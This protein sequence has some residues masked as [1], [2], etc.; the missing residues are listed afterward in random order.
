MS[1]EQIL[2]LEQLEV[3]IY[4]GGV[5]SPDSGYFQRTFG[6][7]VAGQSLVSAVRTVDPRYQVHSLHGYF[8]RPGDAK[9]RT[10]FIV[11]R[12][13]DGGSFATRRV[14]AIQHGEIIFSMG[15]SFQTDQEGIHHQDAM[16]AAPPPDGLPGLD[17]IKVFDDAGFKQFEEWD[18]CIVPREKLQLTPG[19]ASQQQVWFRHRDPL[20]DDPVLHICALAYMS[21]LTLLG[22]AQVTHLDVREHLQV[23]SLDHAMWFMRAFRADKWLL[24]DQSSPSANGGRSLCQGK[25]FT[26]SGEMV[27]AVMQE[28]LTRFQ[29]GYRQ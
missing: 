10:V 3:N 11:E 22:S 8:L 19:K 9:E 28:G 2:D 15:A 17:S 16:P 6:G 26:Q 21:D 20:P 4:R 25:I 23:A 14:N 13:R 18:V 27:A 5:F 7:H 12:T 29:R 24:Y 1:I